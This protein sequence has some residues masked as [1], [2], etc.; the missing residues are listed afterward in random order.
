[1][2]KHL[3]VLASIVIVLALLYPLWAQVKTAGVAHI[4]SL[5]A[6]KQFATA[7]ALLEE[8]V[9]HLL[10]INNADTLKQYI[11][12]KGKILLA[13]KGKVK[14]A[15]ETLKLYIEK[16]S[17]SNIKADGASNLYAYLANFAE[18][19]S[20]IDFAYKA[21][22]K[23]KKIAEQLSGEQ[24]LY[25]NGYHEYNL[26]VYAQKLG[27]ID[28]S[29]SHHRQAIANYS[30]L[31]DIPLKDL[32]LSYS[33]LANI[34]WYEL[35]LDSAAYHFK[36]ALEVIGKMP[37]EPSNKFYR[38][39]L[40]NN[41]LMGICKEKGQMDDA[42]RLGYEI[43]AD[44]Q[45]F[46]KV[47]PPGKRLI[48]AK[49]GLYEVIDNLAGCYD[50]VGD[51]KKSASLKHYSRSQKQQAFGNDFTGVFKS[52]ILLG[53]TYNLL[54]KKEE[55]IHALQQGI[56]GL[57]KS[58]ED[59]SYWLADA[60]S[61]LAF[62]YTDLKDY[63]KAQKALDTASYYYNLSYGD[64]MDNT[65]IDFVRK[66]ALFL[67]QKNKY[68]EAL[69]TA[70]KIE[71]YLVAT[72]ETNNNQYAA[73][74]A[75]LMRI[76]YHAKKYAK[77][78]AAADKALQYIALQYKNKDREIKNIDSIRLSFKSPEIILIKAQ[79]D[80]HLQAK[81]DSAFLQGLY[82]RLDTAL[83]ILEQR[84]L[85]T[86]DADN[87]QN[88][89]EDYQELI[90]FSSKILLDLEKV[91]SGN[92]YL[93]KFINLRE[94]G[95]Y[96]RIRSRLNAQ[97]ALQ[98]STVP[99]AVLEK[100]N[101]LKAALNL[102]E[103]EDVATSM[104]NFEKAT[105]EWNLFIALL[106]KDY[107]KYYEL[108]Y[109]THD[110][111]LLEIANLIPENTSVVR[112]YIIDSTVAIFVANKQVQ[113][114]FTMPLDSLNQMVLKA[115]QANIS[116]QELTAVL[117]D[118]YTKIW[119]PIAHL[120]STSKV[121]IIPDAVLYNINFEMLPNI[122]VRSY[123]E[124]AANCLLNKHTFSSHYSLWMLDAPTQNSEALKNYVAFVPGFSDQS[125]SAYLKTVKD[126]MNI[127]ESYLKLLPQPNS[128]KLAAHLKG[129]LGGALFAN[130]SSTITAFKANA[131]QHKIV[132]VATHAEFNNQNP[133][134]SGLYFSKDTSS[135]NF[136]TLKDIYATDIKANLMLLTAC[137]SGK[138]GYQD[139]EGL[140][141]L[142]HAFNYAGSQNILTAIW[143]IDENSSALITEYFVNAIREGLP[144]DEALRKAKLKYLSEAEGRL[145]A[146]AYWSGLVLMG[147]PLVIDLANNNAIPKW[148]WASTLIA[149]I[150]LL[151][152]F[153]KKKYKK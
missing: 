20:E 38:K 46:I 121:T 136:F 45:S 135:N 63:A 4:E 39:A 122:A 50:Y 150:T 127:D 28:L 70:Q 9:Q 117:S 98:F 21:T 64:A 47:E 142:S 143:K 59:D 23:A 5:I 141:S 49:E 67:S 13:Q 90:N 18:E 91:S 19:H 57:Q 29:N 87:I 2:K 17:K 100:E 11:L 36:K 16:L 114:L 60:H 132:Y 119:Q 35:K 118:I 138:P 126:S 44:Y 54:N 77:A 65:Y 92:L 94:N 58:E 80:Y 61:S 55:A 69:N 15:L 113:E 31:K 97:K 134:S 133:G 73:H 102:I 40:M 123:R 116:E 115:A 89:N 48:S 66:K 33:A 152:L 96:Y 76:H 88:L 147:E 105:N 107:P 110:Y 24:L 30:K 52:D 6:N 56:A 51:Y 153:L 112:Y 84:K 104:S 75:N 14:P 140:V 82:K 34:N 144:T 83:Q 79:S 32:Y 101:K 108:K 7:D 53:Y 93:E 25:F 148:I 1:M 139:G 10:T 95:L 128:Q 99:L 137:E 42:I 41:G 86:S 120:I 111:T 12:L 146:P 78:T 145:L 103:N 3:F 130:E 37:P 124:L 26:G 85:F 62:I 22:L 43:I 131:G 151:V 125:K 81:K 129:K 74:Y 149:G 27:N 8:D 68:Q 72:K 71:D 109:A 106:K